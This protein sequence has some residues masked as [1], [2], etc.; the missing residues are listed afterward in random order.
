[1]A[2]EDY[3][4]SLEVEHKLLD[5]EIQKKYK[6]YLD[7]PQVQSLKKRKLRIKEKILTLKKQLV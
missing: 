6:A 4:Y 2:R 5:Q 7:D 1:M 3:L